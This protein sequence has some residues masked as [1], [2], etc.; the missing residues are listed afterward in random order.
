MSIFRRS[1]ASTQATQATP[2]TVH[3]NA[4]LQPK[5][6]GEIYEDPLDAALASLAPGSEVTGGGSSFTP[7]EGVDS[8]DIELTLTGDPDETI[9]LVIDKLQSLGA[10][11][12]SWARVGDG[13]Q[14]PFGISHGFALALD[15]TSLPD[16]TYATSDINE[17]IGTL[18]EEL[19][20]GCLLQSWWEGP[21]WSSFYFYGLDPELTRTVLESA[22][23]RFPLAENSRVTAIT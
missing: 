22:A 13:P 23:A 10:P 18:I 11:V 8:C 12:G 17:L 2:A 20:D 9:Q 14:I 7:E 1:R 19:G 15:G 6:R 21:E 4:R 5:H 3:L 16:E